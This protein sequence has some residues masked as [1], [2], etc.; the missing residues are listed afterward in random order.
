MN[1]RV[2]ETRP[3]RVDTAT[4]AVT[5]SNPNDREGRTEAFQEFLTDHDQRKISV[6]NTDQEILE[7]F[8]ALRTKKG[9]SVTAGPAGNPFVQLNGILKEL[10]VNLKSPKLTAALKATDTGK[11]RKDGLTEYI[12]HGEKGLITNLQKQGLV[13]ITNCKTQ[14]VATTAT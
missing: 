5:V 11:K 8:V 4:S 12:I 3:R 7:F 14:V 13:S 9:L 10:D 2:G 6:G 1:D